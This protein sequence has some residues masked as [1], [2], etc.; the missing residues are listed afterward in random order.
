MINK[1]QN[2]K[3]IINN[4]NE[5][6][7]E[8]DCIYKVDEILRDYDIKLEDVLS[9]L[10]KIIPKAWR[11][12]D[13]CKVQIIYKDIV[14]KTKGFKRTELKQSANIIVDNYK[15]G[16]INVFYIKPV[17]LE[18]GIFLLE[19]YKLLKIISNKLSDFIIHKTLREAI[20][21]KDDTRFL[22][23]KNIENKYSKLKEWY[24]NMYLSDED[25]ELISKTK[26]KF[27]KGEII[28]KQGSFSSYIIFTIDG[29]VKLYI[30]SMYNKNFI[31]KIIKPFDFIGLTSLFSD[32]NYY[33]FTAKA[34]IPCTIYLIDKNI[35]KKILLKNENFR[36]EILKW[37]CN[38]YRYLYN[39][40]SCITSKQSLGRVA[41]TLLYLTQEIS[42][43]NTISSLISRKDIAEL[44][45]I[46]TENTVRILSELKK[47]GI[48]NISK[49]GIEIVNLKLLKAYNIAG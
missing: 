30:E 28:C 39:K 19:E 34:I 6:T 10:V 37:Y 3:K 13:I 41:N 49:K 35:L 36:N 4:L 47:D 27:K 48:I 1:D 46:T 21:K 38:N 26:V 40:L 17:K 15:V 2:L 33:N 32:D 31:V 45:G 7:K 44:S 8:L 22:D 5:R 11:Y 16:E 18:K 20:E 42:D 14:L 24:K 23:D 9:K 12:P 25:F 29:L 43:N